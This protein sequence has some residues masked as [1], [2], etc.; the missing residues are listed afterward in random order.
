M[1]SQPGCCMHVRAAAAAAAGP[2]GA[3]TGRAE[4]SVAE[5]FAAGQWD[6]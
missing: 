6:G 3:G 1:S 4:Q 2:E 5:Q